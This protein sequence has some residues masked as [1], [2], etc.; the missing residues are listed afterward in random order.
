MKKARNIFA[1]LVIG[2]L[3]VV[4][5]SPLESTTMEN[6][7][8]ADF[9]TWN[10]EHPWSY[11]F[12]LVTYLEDRFAYKNDLVQLNGKIKLKGFKTSPNVNSGIVGLDDWLFYSEPGYVKRIGTAFSENELAQI[13][14][15]MALIKKWYAQ[16][17]IS[18]HFFIVPVKPHVYADKL[19]PLYAELFRNSNLLNLAQFQDSIQTPMFTHCYNELMNERKKDS[20]LY[21]KTDTHWTQPG[22]YIGYKRMMKALQLSHKELVAVNDTM[23]YREPFTMYSGDIQGLFG[24]NAVMSSSTDS[25]KFLDT[26][27]VKM[28][29]IPK[30]V[31]YTTP[32]A[33]NETSIL[34]VR[35]S[36]MES[37]K[38]CV[39]QT[40]ETS[41]YYWDC[42]VPYKVVAEVE[43]QIIVHE[44]LERFMY[45]LL[46]LP[47]E[48]QNDTKFL[49]RHGQL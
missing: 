29:K 32:C 8:L 48:I 21:F 5:F 2:M 15:N 34:F 6:R 46:E 44:L 10:W 39:N 22:A 25:L 38:P 27:E 26:C 47:E 30:I 4:M 49:Q 17:G 12:G 9:P 42:K 18:Y 41:T 23:F 37:M 16:K 24:V 19:P 35:D 43:P 13:T 11:G 7:K 40:F 28:K 31:Q 45:A 33:L 36:F 1:I 20:S 14:T 3:G